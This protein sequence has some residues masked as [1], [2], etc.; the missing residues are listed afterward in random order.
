[1]I[2]RILKGRY[3][4]HEE[5]GSGG[6]STVY[7]GLDMQTSDTIAVKVLHAYVATE[8]ETRARFER[9]AS[10][11]GDLDDPHFVRVLDHG[12]EGEQPFLVMEFVEGSTLKAYI[13][14][15]ITLPAEEALCIARQVAE[16]LAA[17]H[18]R[19]VIHRDVKPQNIMVRPDGSV[20]V[21]DFG[22]AKATDMT[23][24]TKTGFMVGTPH[25]VSPEQA[26]GSV[27]DQR[28]DIYSLGVVLYE[29]LTGGLL[30]SGKTPIA[31]LMKH[32]NEPV[33]ADWAEQ[34]GIA[35]EVADLVNRCLA[36]SPAERY[37]TAE[38]LVAAIGELVCSQKLDLDAA[39]SASPPHP[40]QNATSSLS[41]SF[42]RGND[43][44]TMVAANSRD[45]AT[46]AW[47]ATP[48]PKPVPGSGW[49]IA[50]IR[51][52]LTAAFDNEEL[53]ALRR[54]HFPS[55]YGG[56]TEKLGKRQNIR[57][58]VSY[59]EQYDEM[60]RLLELVREHNPGEYARFESRLGR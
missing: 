40:A 33:P 48:A 3:K 31:I 50:A 41:P 44:S 15:S 29:M 34:Y 51:K 6:V 43:G 1:M 23:T 36:K 37:E 45:D 28:S 22:I 38:E 26:M 57:R 49:N 54:D 14:Q 11:M 53:A 32:L 13:G 56:F 12:Q 52:L 24:L 21:M 17:I 47:Q 60:D 9:E 16:G 30:F 58:L 59:C 4:I 27:S 5:L 55:V 20:K 8:A 10:L 25:Y 42:G 19:G 18:R 39:Q 35:S 46:V 2:G 7:L